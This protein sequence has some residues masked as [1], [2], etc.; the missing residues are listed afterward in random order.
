ML[1]KY[2]ITEHLATE[3]DAIFFALNV[4]KDESKMNTLFKLVVAGM[5]K[6]RFRLDQSEIKFMRKPISLF[7]RS[8][9]R[10]KILDAH[11]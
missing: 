3:R 9:E 6:I 10:R 11:I 4:N 2:K 8:D 7:L 5:R 1:C